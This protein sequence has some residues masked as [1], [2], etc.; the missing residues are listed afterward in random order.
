[1]DLIVT[2]N[3]A[4][5]DA[6][7]SAI[8]AHKLYPNS[9]ILLP[10]S[11]EESVRRFLSLSR[12]IINV[13]TEKTCDFSG[14]DRLVIVDT[15]HR[16]RIGRAG[17]LLDKHIE[18]HIY[19]H[20]PRMTDDIKGDLDVCEEVGS[21]I[22]ILL[23]ILKKHHN[24]KI[25]PLEA[26]IMLLGIYE[27]TGS[28]TYRTTTRSDVD[29][30]SFLLGKGANLQAVSSYL[31]RELTEGELKFLI[32]LIHKTELHIING[33]SISV[34]E[35]D[36]KDFIGE[37]GTIVHKLQEV[38]NYPVLFALFKLRNKVRI[39]ARSREPKVNVNKI[40]EHFDG[41]G[42]AQA[43]TAKIEGS[44]INDIK[45]ELLKILKTSIK[46]KIYAKDI[47]S[48]P[49]KTISL[50]KKIYEAKKLFETLK[51]KGAPCVESGRLAGIITQHDINKALK[52]K[53]GHARVKGYMR[54]K[55][56]TISEN[57]PLHIIQRI[58][59]EKNIGRLPVLKKNK[60]A[61]IVTR[62]DVLKSVHKDIFEPETK[63]IKRQITFNLSGKMR[64]ILPIEYMGLL[65][66]V[67]NESEKAGYS[68]FIVGG[69]VRDILLGVKN[70]DIDIVLEGDAIEFGSI[71]SRKLKGSLVVHRKFGTSAVIIDWP[72]GI[73]K[74]PLASPKLK[75]DLATARRETYE[76][77]AALPSVQ[78]SSIKEDLL[79][80]DFSINAMAVSLN[81]KD[82]G[83][84]VDFFNGLNDLKN[85]KI[86]VLHDAS[87]I[88][89]PTRIF[90][91]VR[92]EQ[93]LSF[94]ID[95]FTERLIKDA[96]K[97]KMFKKTENQRIRE[98]LIIILKEK[99][100]LAA[101]KRMR[102]LHELRFIHRNI[103]INKNAEKMFRSSRKAYDWF[104]KIEPIN[105]REID[106]YVM[107]LGALT[108]NLKSNEVRDFCSK[109]SFKN[110]DT[111][112]L[113]S[114]KKHYRKILET[115]KARGPVCPSEI[116]KALHHF[117]YETILLFWAKSKSA[118]V[119]R[120]ISF[121]LKVYNAAKIKIRGDDIKKLGVKSGP[122]YKKILSKILYLK[123]DGKVKSKKD[124][125]EYARK[126]A[127][128]L[129][130][131]E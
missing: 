109:F 126:I 1:M 42:H 93:R 107:Y 34:I 6:F 80:R 9:E 58:M 88:D 85:R 118:V 77:P 47:M 65:K 36:A 89:D 41:G 10:G 91:A 13:E 26:T 53:F 3:N 57:T 74:P 97:E 95:S 45:N 90:R 69:F 12:D 119:R 110:S 16:S 63:T 38:E 48:K 73:K 105:K 44:Q 103:V 43:A 72:H 21:T 20:H 94:K 100:P 68:A 124:E 120:R 129:E 71:L 25:T 19:D 70:F 40:M 127:A 86:R 4:D 52:H 54:T 96:V 122:Q 28:L 61:G 106:L 123:L 114:Y 24:L 22:T 101:L 83:R 87:F 17:D 59:F 92:F 29:I 116:Y 37:L 125:I 78:F 15:R 56:V 55:V 39:I 18:I 115:L 27:E 66:L 84:L 111:I 33:I 8:A 98:E 50:N 46:V 11:Q 79:R 67:G 7:G 113:Y 112:R 2:H 104:K 60:L 117:S 5:F 121:F 131:P 49:V 102:E 99:A 130:K 108:D 82:F 62:T 128:N 35:A 75:I 51:I 32:E 64:N 76:R 23:N 81:K 30:V 31:N 14:I